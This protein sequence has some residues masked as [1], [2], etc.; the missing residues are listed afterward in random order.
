MG[1][2]TFRRISD[3]I[4][5]RGRDDEHPRGVAAGGRQLGRHL[6]HPLHTSL[7]VAKL[8]QTLNNG[9]PV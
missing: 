1:S 7:K 9:K 8:T 4:S 2:I 5:D 6:Q 3:P